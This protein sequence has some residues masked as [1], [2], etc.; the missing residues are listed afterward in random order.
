MA[1]I[2][3]TTEQRND[4]EIQRRSLLEEASM[5]TEFARRLWT[6]AG[7][8]TE[9]LA[10]DDM[11][12]GHTGNLVELLAQAAREYILAGQLETATRPLIRALEYIESHPNNGLIGLARVNKNRREIL[13]YLT[14][15]L[16]QCQDK[17]AAMK[18]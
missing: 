7:E 5:V 2:E 10:D 6:Q 17:I 1:E 8:A 9:C 18:L 13:D 16:H 12:K 14:E 3:L 15:L 11:A 4:L